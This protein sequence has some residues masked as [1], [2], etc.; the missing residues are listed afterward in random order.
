[1]YFTSTM[2]LLCDDEPHAWYLGPFLACIDDITA[3]TL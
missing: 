2:V 1:M 3:V